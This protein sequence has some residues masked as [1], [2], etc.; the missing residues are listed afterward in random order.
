MKS[1]LVW[2]FY[3]GFVCSRRPEVETTGFHGMLHKWGTGEPLGHDAL[4]YENIGEHQP[5]DL[6]GLENFPRNGSWVCRLQ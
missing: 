3:L 6:V 2:V 5:H 1:A 4:D